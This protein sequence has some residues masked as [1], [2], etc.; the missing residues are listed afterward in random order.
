[1]SGVVKV[2]VVNVAQSQQGQVH[3][4]HI[5][6]GWLSGSCCWGRGVGSGRA[7]SF[8]LSSQK[9][10]QVLDGHFESKYLRFNLIIFHRI[11]LNVWGFSHGIT[12]FYQVNLNLI[13]T[14]KFFK[15]CLDVFSELLT[16][17]EFS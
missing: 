16:L 11:R 8:S 5:V 3:N 12:S 15:T 9:F 7:H 10:S 17:S 1:M 4:I 13:F 2:G 6:I 14:L